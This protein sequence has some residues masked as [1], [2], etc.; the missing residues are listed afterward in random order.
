MTIGDRIPATRRPG[1]RAP[2][3]T[4]HT[5]S[6]PAHTRHTGNPDTNQEP[7]SAPRPVSRDCVTVACP[8]IISWRPD[9]AVD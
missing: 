4:T 2:S 1:E 9:R 6:G 3:G 8:V 5:G 7:T